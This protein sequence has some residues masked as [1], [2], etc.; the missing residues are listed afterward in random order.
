MVGINDM[1]VSFPVAGR[2]TQEI[3]A[4]CP[5]WGQAT[6]SQGGRNLGVKAASQAATWAVTR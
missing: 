2:Q 5:A 3:C 1:Q 4:P 6:R